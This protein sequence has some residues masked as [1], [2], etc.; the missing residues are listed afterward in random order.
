MMP[1]EPPSLTRDHA[2]PHDQ[3]QPDERPPEPTAA[4]SSARQPP[5]AHPAGRSIFEGRLHPLTLVFAGWKAIRWLIFSSIPLFLFL[6]ETGASGL[7]AVAILSLLLV[8]GLVQALARYLSFTYRVEGGELI[9]RQGLLARTERHIPLERVQEIRI[10]QGVLHRLLGVVEARIETAGGE[11]PEASLSVLSR[12]EADALRRAV[13]AR[14][15][16]VAAEGARPATSTATPAA[17]RR[18]VR[19]LSLRELLLAGITSNHLVSAMVILGALWAFVDDLFPEDVYE[20]FAKTVVGAAKGLLAQDVATAIITA[21][22]GLLLV[23]LISLAFS[24]IGSVVLFYGF[25]FS[26]SGEDLHRAY[27]LLTYRTSSLPR[28]RIQVLE[29]EEGLLRRLCRLATLRADTVG[30]RAE[31]EEEKQGGRDVLLPILPRQEV[32]ALLPEFFPDLDE[33]PAPWRRVSRLAIR[34]ETL[35]GALLCALLAAGVTFYLRSPHGLWPLA[36]VP[37]LYWINLRQ[38]AHLGYALGARY[39]RTRRGWLSRSTHIV[40]INKV[41]ALDVRQT[42]FDRRLGLATLVV[43]TAGQAYTGG[44]PLIS[45]LP[46]EEAFAIAR[47]LAQK[48]AVTKYR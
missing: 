41:Q 35:Q 15:A 25:T 8:S 10:E 2:A 37:L 23:L 18:I 33:D 47:T 16:A 31:D 14:A 34:R 5:E 22:A 32:D 27:G 30:S 46:V 9:T 19:Q 38:Y 24:T 42:I 4:E 6:R 36:L 28:R 20:R 26:R 13:S 48:T 3:R 1:S 39:L 12:A 45:H 11:G 7:G 17:G 43:D 44:G 21:L 40:P 29:I